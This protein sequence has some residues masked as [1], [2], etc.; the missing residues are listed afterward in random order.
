VE[1][2]EQELMEAAEL[3][4]RTRRGQAII[5][6]QPPRRLDSNHLHVITLQLDSKDQL[7]YIA[8]STVLTCLTL[9]AIARE[10]LQ[11]LPLIPQR[12]LFTRGA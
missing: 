12:S 10:A 3:A 8:E 1:S 5:P 6:A 11:H 4:A 7:D 2:V 9:L